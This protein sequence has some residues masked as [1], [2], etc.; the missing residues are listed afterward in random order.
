[1]RIVRKLAVFLLIAGP[2]GA[3]VGITTASAAYPSTTTTLSAVTTPVT[4][5]SETQTFT[6]TVVGDPDGFYG[7]PL[8]T[9]AVSDGST[10][11]CTSSTISSFTNGYTTVYTCSDSATAEAAGTYTDVTATYTAGSPSSTFNGVNYNGSV[12]TP[13]QTIVVNPETV[14]SS[15]GLTIV[16]GT[17]DLGNEQVAVFTAT[18][19]G[20]AGEGSPEGTPTLTQTVG[21]GGVCTLS[22]LSPASSDSSTSTCSPTSSQYA[23]GATYSFTA[24]YPGGA[25]TNP[26]FT[27]SA[28]GP[29]NT[30]TLTVNTAGNTTTTLGTITS[31]VTFGAEDQ[32]FTVTVTGQ[33]GEGH[34]LG[35]VT[36]MTGSTTLCTVTW[37]AVPST[38]VV[39]ASADSDTVSC[40]MTNNSQLPASGTGYSVFAT[41][42]PGSPSSDV[43]FIDYSG[44]FSAS[45]TLQVN[46]SGTLT[47]TTASL[48]GG[49][50]GVSYSQ[51]VNATG[52]TPPLTWTWAFASPSTELPPGLG[53]NSA[54]GNISGIPTTT[55]AFTFTVTVTDS[56]S[57]TNASVSKTYTINISSPLV[58]TTSSRL[59]SAHR[60]RSYSTPLSVT[61]GVGPY[62]WAI[63]SGS[64]P[65]SIRVNSSTGVLSGEAGGYGTFT[66]TVTVTDSSS[67]N[68][69]TSKTF[70][71]SV[72]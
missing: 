15:I 1:L 11:L 59:P 44:S 8:G 39:A 50:P 72:S 45:Q 16:P 66:F 17:V 7:A 5:G 29:S 53:I 27:Y 36:V 55:G 35:T 28:S 10:T 14:A 46:G 18:V 70:T 32:T 6:V 2:I 67:P 65:G 68:A 30:A 49:S 34:P 62:H 57:P 71:I 33:S 21:S 56:S 24:S 48:P 9:V 51:T 38:N 64:A 58:I 40:P 20:A 69:S 47:I 13:A 43:A 60:A 19:T 52:G 3:L 37:T 25:S 41:F 26:N 4:Y 12:S 61:G 23:A 22:A 54:T 42:T 63:T 31:P